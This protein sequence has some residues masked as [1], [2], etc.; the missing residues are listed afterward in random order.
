[1]KKSQGLK[2]GAF[3]SRKKRKSKVGCVEGLGESAQPERSLVAK[4]LP[5]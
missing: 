4:G 3:G 2:E 1:M 5:N